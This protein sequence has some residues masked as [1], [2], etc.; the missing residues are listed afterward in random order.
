MNPML[1]N[2]DDQ[3]PQFITDSNLFVSL[4]PDTPTS[5][6]FQPDCPDLAFVDIIWQV[7]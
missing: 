1:L 7:W 5:I 4:V 2:R 6:T 3:C